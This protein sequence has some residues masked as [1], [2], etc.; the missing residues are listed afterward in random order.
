M[1]AANR[2]L[3]QTHAGDDPGMLKAQ[4]ELASLQ[5]KDLT[6]SV[7]QVI[8]YVLGGRSEDEARRNEGS[9]RT[10]RDVSMKINAFGD[11]NFLNESLY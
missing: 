2:I 9:N 7:F 5:G 10:N 3:A 6:Q 1:I 8:E 4:T 11:S